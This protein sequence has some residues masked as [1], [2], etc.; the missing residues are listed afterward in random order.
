M[1]VPWLELVLVVASAAVGWLMKHFGI[2][3]IPTNKEK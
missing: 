3:T 1:A 2:W